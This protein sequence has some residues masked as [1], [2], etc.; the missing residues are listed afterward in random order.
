MYNLIVSFLFVFAS[1]HRL[2][3]WTRKRNRESNHPAAHIPQPLR[4]VTY[5]PSS[6]YLKQSN[7]ILGKCKALLGKPR[8]LWRLSQRSTELFCTRF[9]E[10]RSK[11]SKAIA[12]QCCGTFF[13]ARTH[14]PTHE[15]DCRSTVVRI[16]V[17]GVCEVRTLA[18]VP[19]LVIVLDPACACQ[20]ERR[21][22]LKKGSH[23]STVVRS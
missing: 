16:Q 12:E 18:G 6:H 21:R 11:K 8:T 2:A 5:T 13:F 15:F 1:A 20:W 14:Q 22:T 19:G 10:E 3:Y 23:N 17:G 7:T 9:D 4:Y